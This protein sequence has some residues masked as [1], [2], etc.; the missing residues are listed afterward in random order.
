[1]KQ[2]PPKSK[3]RK[4]VRDHTAQATLRGD[5][6]EVSVKR[7][8]MSVHGSPLIVPV[9]DW[10]EQRTAN[11]MYDKWHYLDSRYNPDSSPFVGR[12]LDEVRKAI[13]EVVPDAPATTP[14]PARDASEKPPPGFRV[15][16]F[17]PTGAGGWQSGIKAPRTRL[18]VLYEMLMR[19]GFT[20]TPQHVELFT[21]AGK[22]FYSI[23]R[24]AV[25]VCLENELTRDLF[26]AMATLQPQQVLC[27]E[28][29]FAGDATLREYAL[30]LLKENG[31]KDLVTV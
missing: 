8:R 16:K 24:D 9:A 6:V 25:L 19:G 22:Q 2:K 20:L 10:M 4:G 15:L 28:R 3:P 12:L 30:A 13:D 11:R 7:G 14:T 18:D 5:V 31:V 27:L 1:M 26:L 23:E 17:A 29:G 21:L